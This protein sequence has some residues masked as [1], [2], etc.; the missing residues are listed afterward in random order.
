MRL[1]PTPATPDRAKRIWPGQLKHRLKHTS[2]ANRR[3]ATARA[4]QSLEPNL[5]ER[6]AHRAATLS[7]M[8]FGVI[9]ADEACQ[10]LKISRSQMYKLLAKYR[11]GEIS[12]I[13]C[14]SRGRPS[15][16]SY[17]TTVRKQVLSLVNEKYC[18]FGPTLAAEMLLE[19]HGI[20]I[21]RET[22]RTWMIKDGLWVT[23]RAARRRIHR[24]RK[25]M[26]TYGDLVQIDGSD[27]DWFEDRAPRC[28][29]MVIVDDATGKLQTLHFARTEDRNAYFRAT[30]S[31]V[32]K[33]G[34]PVRIV[35]DKHSAVWS[36]EGITQYDEALSKLNIIHSVAHSPQ[37]KGRVERCHRTLQDRLVKRLRLAG[38]SSIDEANAFA[39]EFIRD[40]NRRF[41]KT[42][43]R[44]G[45]N[46]RPPLSENDIHSAFSRC[47]LRCV[48]KNLSF[49][50]AGTQYVIED[51]GDRDL[52]GRKVTVEIQIDRG[53]RVFGACGELRVRTAQ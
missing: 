38:V 13:A 24:S 49:S 32:M 35:T 19:I 47:Y 1:R 22:L 50:L 31:Y 25:R 41:A 11:K 37:S 14:K 43:A 12:A 42:A 51:V 16:R 33:H 52:I 18:D 39:P 46:H 5:T 26:P 3:G 15:N 9:T 7:L 48:T 2:S 17:P 23:N 40:Y 34:R 44:L 8:E 20:R 53:M 36:P 29:L 30:Y 10:M 45:D 27:H 28:T 4:S 6:D 21:S